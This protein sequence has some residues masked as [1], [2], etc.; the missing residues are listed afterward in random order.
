MSRRVAMILIIV[1]VLIAF[2]GFFWLYETRYMISRASVAITEFSKDN[3]YVFVS[4]LN[5]K[6]NNDEKIRVTVFVLNN[7]GLGVIG[8]QVRLS[9]NSSLTTETIQG[10]TDATGKAVFDVRAFTAGD[11]YLD[12]TVDDITLPQKARANFF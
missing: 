4:P 2:S 11:Y 10:A 5:A 9:P 8:R 12:I 6:A 7:Q 1:F 3:S